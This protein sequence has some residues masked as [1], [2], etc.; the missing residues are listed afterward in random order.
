MVVIFS[1]PKGPPR[2]LAT[3]E[4]GM[5]TR[6]VVISGIPFWSVH[7]FLGL[8]SEAGEQAPGERG[9]WKVLLPCWISSSRNSGLQI[10]SAR[11]NKS[12]ATS[13]WGSVV[14][15]GEIVLKMIFISFSFIYLSIVCTRRSTGHRVLR[16]GYSPFLSSSVVNCMEGS[17]ALSVE[18]DL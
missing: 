17:N 10:Q 9:R 12:M 6:W 11:R 15:G 1:G 14:M 18:G 8:A 7:N 13:F 16:K 5:I 2:D 3:P 4:C